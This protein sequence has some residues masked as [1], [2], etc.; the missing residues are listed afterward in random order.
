[1]RVVFK[2]R[3]FKQKQNG[4]IEHNTQR[5]PKSP[6][7]RLQLR[8]RH[9]QCCKIG[10]KRTRQ[11]QQGINGLPIHIKVITG[12]QLKDIATP[13]AVPAEKEGA[14]YRKKQQ[15]MNRIKQHGSNLKDST[16]GHALETVS[17]THNTLSRQNRN[18]SACP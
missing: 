8:L 9:E 7:D 17:N 6:P 16:L 3:L 12:Q 5:E 18:H 15:E 2:D 1:M 10:D 4:E 11:Q 13:H 14:N